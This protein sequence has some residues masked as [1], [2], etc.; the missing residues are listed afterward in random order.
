MNQSI[1]NTTNPGMNTVWI[2]HSVHHEHHQSWYPSRCE[3][4]IQSIMNTTYPG[5]CPG[6]NQLFS[7]S[8]TPPSRNES[9]IQSIMNTTNPGIHLGLNLSFSPS[10]TP[11]IPVSVQMWISHL[12][13]KH[14]QSCYPSR[15]ELVIQSI[16]NTTNPGIHPGMNQTFSPS[17]TPPILV[18]AQMWIRHSVHHEHHQS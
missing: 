5:I 9:V 17:W 11:P 4:D 8:W 15:Y 14:Y 6:M 13:H 2:R 12:V 10:W 18:S 3:S 16:M 1:M 7:P